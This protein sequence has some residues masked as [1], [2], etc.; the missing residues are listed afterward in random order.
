[1]HR[2]DRIHGHNEMADTSSRLE[3][4]SAA[5]AI[6][7]AATTSYLIAIEAQVVLVEI[8]KL[9]APLL[10]GL[11]LVDGESHQGADLEIGDRRRWW[12]RLLWRGDA[13]ARRQAHERR[14]IER[15][16]GHRWWQGTTARAR[17]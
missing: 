5:V 17:G 7:A 13:A 15:D 11:C 6:A 9:F 12:Q 8:R 1:M 3:I 16:F 10:L 2:G 4:E 14:R